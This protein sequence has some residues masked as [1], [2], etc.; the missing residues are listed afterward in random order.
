M[1]KLKN[2]LILSLILFFFVL[3]CC[4]NK[5]PFS[6]SEL[7]SESNGLSLVTGPEEVIIRLQRAYADR[8]IDLY[9]DCLSE[10]FIFFLQE[11]DRIYYELNENWWDKA[12]EIRI[13]RN[14]FDHVSDM[15]LKFTQIS[16]Q[17]IEE[18]V[19]ELKYQYQLNVYYND[20][21]YNADGYAKFTV[22]KNNDAQWVIYR[23]YDLSY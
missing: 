3:C 20:I 11:E 10:E 16:S 7:A 9:F 1:V 18:G 4:S 14:L 12:T 19:H 2:K 22:I 17:E 5:N 15:Q 6:P 8:D 13:Q 21:R 23:W